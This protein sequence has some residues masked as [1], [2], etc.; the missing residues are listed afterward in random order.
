ME[1]TMTLPIPILMVSLVLHVL[2]RFS[3][4]VTVLLGSPATLSQQNGR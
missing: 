3:G 1:W 2:L 4:L